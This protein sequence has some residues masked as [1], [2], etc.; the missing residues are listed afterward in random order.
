LNWQAGVYLES[1]EP[2]G[3][4][5]AQ[6]PVFLRCT[7][8]STFQCTNPLGAIIPGLGTINYNV[9]RTSFHDI[10]LYAQ[11]TYSLTDKLKLTGG[12]RYTWDRQK[13]DGT[14]ITYVFPGLG[15][16][17]SIT[18]VCTNTTQSYPGCDVHYLAKSSAPTW[19]IDVDYKPIGDLLL[20][21]KYARGYRAGGISTGAPP[22]TAVFKP[23][24]VDTFEGG[25][26]ASFQGAVSGSF[27]VAGFYNNFT[28]QQLSLGLL[29]IDG[30]SAPASA[31]LNAGKSRIYGAEVEASLTP[32]RGLIFNVSYAYINAKLQQVTLPD[33]GG[34]RYVIAAGQGSP[35]QEIRYTPEN[36]VSATATYTL[37]LDPSIGRIALS[38]NFVHVDRQRSAYDHTL[39]GMQ[40]SLDYAPP[41]DLLNL[42]LNWNSV[43]GQPFDISLFATNVTN[44]HYFS[45]VNDLA[46]STGFETARQG[47]PRMFGGRLRFRFGS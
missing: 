40:A 6:S 20:Y 19:L 24:K 36:Q 9:A 31:V 17:G 30:S 1:S 26:K 12:F 5:G 8:A 33:L 21:A 7:D 4:S 37:P 10:G 38:T 44:K 25:L 23:E 42:S 34:S 45:Y 18:P 43:A 3:L 2:M 41:K 35:G 47:E 16:P 28:N 39:I 22:V 14:L 32:V 13:A 15:V 29:S 11:G 27:N 46:S